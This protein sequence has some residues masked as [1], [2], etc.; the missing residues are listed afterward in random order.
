MIM[1]Q[2]TAYCHEMQRF[3][4]GTY[5]AHFYPHPKVT[6]TCGSEPVLQVL[7]SET[8]ETP[9]CYW[10]YWDNEKSKF[11]HI[12]VAKFLVDMC[13]A[14]GVQSEIKLG[15]GELLPVKIERCA[16]NE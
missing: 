4:G 8:T 6:Q 14:Y 11:T 2:T 7:V 16:S 5:Y 9:D 15:R 12:Y 1:K 13:F 3:D 10:A